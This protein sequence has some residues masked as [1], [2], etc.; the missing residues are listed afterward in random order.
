MS[1]RVWIALIAGVFIISVIA[2]LALRGAPADHVSVY[3]DGALVRS[4][5]LSNVDEPF[6]FVV[7]SDAGTNLIA[8]ERGRICVADADCHDGSCVR[9]GWLSGGAAPVVCLPHR[10]VIQME[11]SGAP[12]LD[13]V[14][15]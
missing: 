15:G 2:V 14:A 4:V 13:A 8:V 10:L 3:S 7:E 6:T 1:N 9:Q 12:D 5:V 11:Q